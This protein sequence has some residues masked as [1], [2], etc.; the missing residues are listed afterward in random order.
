MA[1]RVL[2]FYN[3]G[4]ANFTKTKPFGPAINNAR[5]G[6][7]A[8]LNNDGYIDLVVGDEI[9]GTF[10]CIN[11]KKGGLYDPISFG[12]KLVPYSIVIGD[13]NNDK[14]S[15]IVVGYVDSKTT[16]F[17][18][19]GNGVKFTAVKFGD[20]KGSVYGMALGDINKD[21]FLDIGVACT[22]A[23]NVLYISQKLK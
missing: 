11:D 22:D 12:E 3:D 13:L 1:G 10:I 5:T 21:G 18:N 2:L 4:K 8:D 6:A 16:A 15:D 7:T 20:G 19:D 17:F 23:S 9:S 14:K